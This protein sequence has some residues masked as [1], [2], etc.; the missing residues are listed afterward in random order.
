M[1]TYNGARYIREQLDS[2]ASQ[3]LLP[4]EIVITDD[5]SSDETIAIVEQFA[6]NAPFSVRLIR[7]SERLGFTR[8]FETA[9]G[10]CE[11][12]LIFLSDQDDSWFPRKLEIAHK[13]FDDASTMAVINDQIITDENLHHANHTMTDNLRTLGYNREALVSGCSSGIRKAWSDILLPIPEKA[14]ALIAVGFITHDRWINELSTLLGVRKQIEE[15]L[16]YFRRYGGNASQSLLHDW[17]GVAVTDLVENRLV[18]PPVEAWLQRIAALRIYRNWMLANRARIERLGL[19]NVEAAL[20]L[21]DHEHRS[22]EARVALVRQPAVRRVMSIARLLLSGGY[23]YFHGP[24]SA[25]RD[26]V[27][28][29]D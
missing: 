20:T 15:P 9:I 25:A 22:L 16:Q 28:T 27:R 8:N 10:Y 14:E 4:D 24:V 19:S 2:F 3:T 23:R 18:H 6:R 12:A 17:R 29:G 11:G 7:N 26:L 5:G 13:A 21:I 1:A